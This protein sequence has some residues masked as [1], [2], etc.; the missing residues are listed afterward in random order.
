MMPRS[1]VAMTFRGFPQELW[2]LIA[3]QAVNSR[4]TSTLLLLARLSRA[5]ADFALPRM[6]GIPY[7]PHQPSSEY[8]KYNHPDKQS[9]SFWRSVIVSSLGRTLYPYCCWINT[10]DFSSLFLFLKG[11]SKS[12]DVQLRQNFYSTPLRY[13][14]LLNTEMPNFRSVDGSGPHLL[15]CELVTKITEGIKATVDQGDVTSR[16]AKIIFPNL[17]YPPSIIYFPVW[18]SRLTRLRALGLKDARLLTDKAA[19]A[20]ARNCPA[21]QDFS[22]AIIA[23]EE[24]ENHLAILLQSLPPNTMASFR[25]TRGIVHGQKI[26]EAL[27]RH[28]G[29]LRRLVLAKLGPRALSAL[30]QLRHCNALEILSLNASD[31]N[32][33]FDFARSETAVYDQF[34]EWLRGC[35]QLK[36]L[37]LLRFPSATQL[38]KDSLIG[39][40]L[41][42][43]SLTLVEVEASAPWYNEL[44]HQAKLECLE[45]VV[46]DLGLLA[47]GPASGRCQGLAAGISRCPELTELHTEDYLSVADIRK[48]SEGALKLERIAFSGTLVHDEHIMPLANLPRLK[49]VH[50]MGDSSFTASGILRFFEKME[51]NA[52]HDHRGFSFSAAFQQGTLFGLEEDRRLR[53]AAE[54]AFDGNVT[55]TYVDSDGEDYYRERPNRNRFFV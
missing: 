13:L 45:I 54:R 8:R 44:H 11:I 51:G 9:V 48:I 10:F 15:F 27:D 23:E 22:C 24:T 17:E 5:M 1:K 7:D 2:F 38:L 36:D 43:E 35:Y 49:E 41:R 18:I 53:K 26:L 4:D 3:E 31:V 46:P 37:S 34:V 19:L 39:P 16:L 40:K 30:N 55:I 12:E 29:S 28:S 50:V 20:L 33:H 52:D 21:L 25:V 42:L 14:E 47:L 6:Y 32:A